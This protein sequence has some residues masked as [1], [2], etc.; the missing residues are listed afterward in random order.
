LEETVV[1]YTWDHSVTVD[2]GRQLTARDAMTHMTNYYA[3][4]EYDTLQLVDT[5]SATPE[6]G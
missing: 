5:D 2:G 3:Y 1:E 4:D 6:M